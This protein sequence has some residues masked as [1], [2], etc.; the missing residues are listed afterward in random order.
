[1]TAQSAPATGLRERKKAKTRA[2]IQRHALRLF[3]K[4]GYDET[5]VE[6]IAAAAE[7][8]PSTFF[9]YFPT[10]EDVVIYDVFDPV[11]IAAFRAQ[12]RQLGPVA[13]MRAAMRSVFA[14]MDPEDMEDLREREGLLRTVPELR[15]RMMDEFVQTMRLLTQLIA[16]RAGRR[17][18]D[19]SV[20]TVAGA[21]VGA[22]ISVWMTADHI[23]FD[24]FYQVMDEAL[25]KLESGLSL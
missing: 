11:I 22:V 19:I 6:D 1:M 18:S 21:L 9:R 15:G 20:R 24:D 17:P 4:R 2:A 16:E 25:E 5:T 7:V 14:K 23:R 12:P 10:K 13:A 3:K 8:S